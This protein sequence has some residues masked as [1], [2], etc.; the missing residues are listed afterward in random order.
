[1]IRENKKLPDDVLDKLPE[2]VAVIS[3]DS[4]VA[5]LY[6]IGSLSEGRLTPLSDLDFAVLLSNRLDKRQR[7]EKH[8]E[9]IGVFN[10]VFRTDEIDLVILNDAHLRFCH[11]TL[12][13]GKLLYLR[14]KLDLVNFSEKI[15]KLYLD[16]RFFRDGFDRVFL[17]GVGYNG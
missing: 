10:S 13:T 2:I 14:N 16:F 7:F 4:T 11:K 8:I 5:A 1:M 15:V 12:K 3:S 9:L 17:E 6:S